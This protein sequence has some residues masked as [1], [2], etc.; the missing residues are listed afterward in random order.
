MINGAPPGTL[1][2]FKAS[3]WST[4]E[5]FINFLDHFIKHAHPTKE[6]K[7]LIL[8]DNHETH[9]SIQAKTKT[10]ENGIVLLTI[11]PHPSP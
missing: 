10:R 2:T 4:S 5:I 1:G 7:T 9:V 3:G 6:K 11:P 8:M